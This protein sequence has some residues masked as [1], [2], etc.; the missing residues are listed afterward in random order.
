[1]ARLHRPKAK[2]QQYRPKQHGG[3]PKDYANANCTKQNRLFIDLIL[4][5]ESLSR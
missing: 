4:T 1:M 5:S 3:K 2:F